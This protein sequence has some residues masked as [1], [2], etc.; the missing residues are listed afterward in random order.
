VSYLNGVHEAYVAK[1]LGL[2][3]Y[4]QLVA[5]LP[6]HLQAGF[7]QERLRTRIEPLFAPTTPS[8]PAMVEA[9]QYRMA[10]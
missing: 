1:A 6:A 2:A 8:A 5:E 9:T 4:Q 3:R 10:A 7:V